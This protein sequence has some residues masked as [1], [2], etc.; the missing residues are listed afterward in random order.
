MPRAGAGGCRGPGPACHG[1]RTAFRRGRQRRRGP[2]SGPMPAV[3][4]PPPTWARVPGHLPARHRSAFALWLRADDARAPGGRA[5]RAFVT[6]VPANAVARAVRRLDHLE[7]VALAI[8]LSDTLGLQDDSVFDL[9]GHRPTSLTSGAPAPWVA[10]RRA[11]T[12]PGVAG[13]GIGHFREPDRCPLARG[14]V[15]KQ[16]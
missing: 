5:D 4:P 15:L 10:S 11:L 8:S 3:P 12:R 7:D 14:V 13:R 9:G 6:V 1:E 16:P 2:H